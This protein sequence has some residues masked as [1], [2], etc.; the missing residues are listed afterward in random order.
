MK[1]AS[2]TLFNQKEQKHVQWF[3]IPSHKNTKSSVELAA[4][5]LGNVTS[6]CEGV[7][8]IVSQDRRVSALRIIAA[9]LT[10]ADPQLVTPVSS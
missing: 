2:F 9:R 3:I 1:L 4:E 7:L 8:Y 10:W 6:D 5:A